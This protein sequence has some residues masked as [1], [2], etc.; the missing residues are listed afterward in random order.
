[1]ALTSLGSPGVGWLLDYE[2]S[3]VGKWS[4]ALG[5]KGLWIPPG[6]GSSGGAVFRASLGPPSP[7]PLGLREALEKSWSRWRE[8]LGCQDPHNETVHKRSDAC[9][10]KSP[11]SGTQ[12]PALP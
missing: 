6:A 4:Q 10:K 12:T 1:M 8:T 3:Q 11:G 5:E 2:W 7:T 9:V